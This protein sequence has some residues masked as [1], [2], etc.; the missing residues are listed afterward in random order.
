M[1]DNLVSIM[2][3]EMLYRIF[4]CRYCDE[5]ISTLLFVGPC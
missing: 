1:C 4:V 3:S 5:E 2:G